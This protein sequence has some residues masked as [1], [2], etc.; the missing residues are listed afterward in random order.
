VN[1]RLDSRAKDLVD[2]SRIMVM[3]KEINEMME[4]DF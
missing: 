1:E 2:A 4:K 3:K